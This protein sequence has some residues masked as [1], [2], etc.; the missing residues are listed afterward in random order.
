M[1]FKYIIDKTIRKEFKKKGNS[2]I[3]YKKGVNE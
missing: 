1:P 2:F 3:T